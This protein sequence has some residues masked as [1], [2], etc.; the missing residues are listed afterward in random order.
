MTGAMDARSVTHGHIDGLDGLRGVALLMVVVAHLYLLN[1]GWIGMQ[2]FF[3]LSGFLITRVLLMDRAKAPG[4]GSYLKRFYIRRLWRIL[5]LYY[6]YL[7]VMVIVTEAN[8]PQRGHLIYAFAYLYNFFTL[9]EGRVHSFEFDHLWSMSVEEQ[10]YLVWPFVLYWFNNANLRKLLVGLVVVGAGLRALT[11]LTWPFDIAPSAQPWRPLVLYV[12]TWSYLD[13]F[14]IGALINFV[15]L[16]PRPVH[17]LIYGLAMMAVG[18]AVNGIGVGPVFAD[19]PYLSLGW[20]LYMPRGGQAVWGYSIVNGFLFL[21]ICLIISHDAS[22]RLFSHPVL[23]F[24]GKRSYP[25][26][27]VHYPILALFLPLLPKLIEFTGHRISGTLIFGLLYLP[28]VLLVADLAHR[29]IELPTINYGR[30]FA[31]RTP[32][33]VAPQPVP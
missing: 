15:S 9:R 2:S 25:T 27:L 29:Y 4:F 8:E 10:F 6:G 5:P 3:V 33:P 31:P 18:M 23:D 30:R 12:A 21:S 17:L 16:R 14:A 24:L 20:P 22:R 32:A 19:G 1:F 26:Y 7:M 11:W 13:A 28:P